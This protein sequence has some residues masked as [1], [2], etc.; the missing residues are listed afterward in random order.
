MKFQAILLF[1][2]L[3]GAVAF[4]GP[5]FQAPLSAGKSHASGAR[6]LRMENFGLGIGEDSYANT[7]RELLGEANYKT[8]VKTYN[9]KG[10]L[11]RKYDP[12]ERIAQL[13][14][15]TAT[16][17]SGLLE[18][19]ESKGVTLSTVEALL[20]VAEKYG[21][22]SVAVKNQEFLLNTVAPLAIEPAPAVL[23]L[24]VGLLE[25]PAVLNLFAIGLVAAEGAVVVLGQNV[26]LDVIAGI[27]LLGGAFA[28]FTLS[29]ILGDIKGTLDSLAEA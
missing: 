25:N 14:L 4:T 19:L 15:L 7:P 1:C 29:S 20:P 23:P 27:P 10:L 5:K 3:A 8:T 12:V 11:A 22:I 6:S 18:A 2:L 26:T 21:L 9:S 13:K 17:D 28:L 24:L 16:A